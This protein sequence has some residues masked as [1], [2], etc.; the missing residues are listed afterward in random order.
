MHHP[1]LLTGIAVWD[2]M[3]LAPADRVAL[4]AVIERHP[5]VRRLVG[6]HFHLAITAELAG[7]T[8]LTAPSTYTQFRLDFDVGEIE[9]AADP[10][11]FV[12]HAV[13]DGELV[14]HFQPV[15]P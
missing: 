15:Q 13:V 10:A 2:A 5:Q 3:G 4:G 1:P 12:L 8:V 6:G 11:G 9:P 7:R 14:S